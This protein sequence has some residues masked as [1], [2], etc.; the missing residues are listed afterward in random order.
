MLAYS[1]NELLS[2]NHDPVINRSV[3]KVLFA[4][5]LWRR[6]ALRQTL[7][8]QANNITCVDIAVS[9]PKPIHQNVSSDSLD[10]SILSR[11]ADDTDLRFSL[12]NVQSI[13]NKSDIVSAIINDDKLDILALTETWHMSSDDLQLRRAVPQG[14][15]YLDAARPIPATSTQN[16][17]HGS[18][19]VICQERFTAKKTDTWI[20]SVDV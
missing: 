14:Y 11:S 5:R 13:S 12:L 20:K 8:P 3:R 18:V 7:N 9:Q 19:V 6:R 2:F 16:F 15:K 4:L 17:N 10:L 1:A